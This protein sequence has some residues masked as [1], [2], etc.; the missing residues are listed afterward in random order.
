MPPK[1]K[2]TSRLAVSAQDAL[3]S[4]VESQRE[5]DA[6]VAV[7]NKAQEALDAAQKELT[8]VAAQREAH[9]ETLRMA[10]SKEA[11]S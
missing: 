2:P 3:E 9:F 7:R 5:V 10:I 1:R 11:K 8:K 4:L 6:A